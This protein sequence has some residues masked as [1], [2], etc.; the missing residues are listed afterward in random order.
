MKKHKKCFLVLLLAALL[1]LSSCLNPFENSPVLSNH[2]DAD[3]TAN[4]AGATTGGQKYTYVYNSILR[5]KHD[6]PAEDRVMILLTGYYDDN[7]GGGG[8]FYWDAACTD[9]PDDGLVIAPLDYEDKAGRYLRVCDPTHLNV[10][11]FGAKGDGSSDDTMAIQAAIDAL[12]TNGGEV[13]L[14]G[15]QY[16]VTDTLHIGDGDGTTPST[17]NGIKLIGTGAQF[18]HGTAVATTLVCQSK[19]ETVV[20]VH[21]P[22]YDCVMQGFKINVNNH[23][24]VGMEITAMSGS[25]IERLQVICHNKTGIILQ[26]GSGEFG[27]SHDNVFRQF[28]SITNVNDSVMIEIGGNTESDC[29]VRNCV[30]SDCRFDTG[31]QDNAVAVHMMRA[32]KMTFQR[33][34]F[35]VYKFDTSLGLLLDGRSN[36]GYPKQN[37]YYD[38]SITR[39]AVEESD[40]GN[41]GYNFLLGNGSGDWE[42]YESHPKLFGISDKGHIIGVNEDLI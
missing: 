30:F 21:G 9:A 39:L 6:A 14:P 42:T 35:N 7:D 3:S 12:P 17:K 26:A 2:E 37:S 16:A 28:G 4:E 29:V 32:E 20:A 19:I 23:A 8:I 41:I 5:M 33:C 24:N 15:G 38:C 13:I 40:N 18:G 27:D 22:I 25:R 36:N 34:H 11:W 1:L 10:K 31:Q